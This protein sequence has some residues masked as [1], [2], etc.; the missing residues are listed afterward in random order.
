MLWALVRPFFPSP[1]DS[2]RPKYFKKDTISDKGQESTI[3]KDVQ[4][5][6]KINKNELSQAMIPLSVA[7]VAVLMIF[8]LTEEEMCLLQSPGFAVLALSISADVLQHVLLN[9][10]LAVLSA[11]AAVVRSDLDQW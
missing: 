10:L 6:K 8:S 5:K 7:I 4:S 3:Q 11:K 9:F 2:G 1:L